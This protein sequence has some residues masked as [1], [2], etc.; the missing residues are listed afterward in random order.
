MGTSIHLLLL[1]LPLGDFINRMENYKINFL[2]HI[3]FLSNQ[4]R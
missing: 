1:T 4:R 3:S 2:Y